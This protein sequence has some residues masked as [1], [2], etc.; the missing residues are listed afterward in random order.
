MDTSVGTCTIK[1]NGLERTW[2]WDRDSPLHH[3]EQVFR[4][5][6]FTVFGYLGPPKVLTLLWE[7]CLTHFYWWELSQSLRYEMSRKVWG[8][9][10][11]SGW[12]AT[13]HGI[14]GIP[15]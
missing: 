1:R 13:L 14:G 7:I 8:H 9:C 10:F 12:M 11:I 6:V 3:W 4:E 5:R 15:W 2:V